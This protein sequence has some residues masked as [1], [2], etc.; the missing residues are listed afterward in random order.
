[1]LAIAR[2]DGFRVYALSIR[3]GQR[4]SIELEAA[5]A[6]ARSQGVEEH[7]EV[8][9]DLDRFGGSAIT[10][11][12]EVPKSASFEQRGNDPVPITYVPARNTVFLSL[13][14]AWAEVIEADDIFM[15]IHASTRGGYPDT[16]PEFITA[17]ERLAEVATNRGVAGD[18]VRVHTPLLTDF[19][20]GDI[21]RLGVELGVDYSVTRTCFDPLPGGEACGHCDACLLRLRG[22]SDAGYEDPAPYI[23]TEVA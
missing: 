16:R 8:S 17:F 22:F 6:V 14:L 15:G 18:P 1:M 10:A 12:M 7:L 11:D 4:N 9:V 20:K 5:S 21:I 3:Y 23:A 13:A 19:D 2:R